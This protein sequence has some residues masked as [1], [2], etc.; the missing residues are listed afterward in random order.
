MYGDM[1]LVRPKTIRSLVSETRAKHNACTV[2]SMAPPDPSGYGRIDASDDGAVRAIIEDEDC[3]PE[4]R[5][6]LREC[7]SGLYCFCGRR[8]FANIDRITSDNAQGEY[9][10]TDM[11]GIYVGMGELVSVVHADDYH[12]LLGVNSCSQLAV[13]TKVMQRRIKTWQIGRASCRERV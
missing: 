11:V 2:L 6:T 13:A 10:L 1:P 3:T 12:E 4:Q 9:Y 8:L 5:K 7:N